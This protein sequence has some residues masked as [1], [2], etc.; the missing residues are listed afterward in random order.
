M[1]IKHLE[2]IICIHCGGEL[3]TD[4]QNERIKNGIIKC[5][6]CDAAFPVINYIPRLLKDELLLNC[7]TF[8]YDEHIKSNTELLAFHNKFFKNVSEK[9]INKFK[10]LKLDTQKTFGYEWKIWKK[11][12]DYAEN[13]F[14]EVVQIEPKYFKGK[15][16]WD[17]AVGMG[18]FLASAVEA[19]GEN[20]F[21]IGSDLS[22]AVDQAFERCKNSSNILIVQA[23]LY[24]DIIKNNSL[25]FAYMI[26]L[27]QHLTEPKK[28]VEQ[29]F[30]KVKNEGY[31]AGTYYNQPNKNDYL[32]RMVIATI[33][34][35]RIFTT[36]LPLPVVLFISRL[37]AL[38]SYLFFKLPTFILKKFNYI[39]EM[40][41]LY[42]TH[43]TQK[44]KP[45]FDLLAHNWFDHFTPPVINFFSE[46]EIMET[47]KDISTDK[48]TYKQGVLLCFKK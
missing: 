40:E 20:G 4:N 1:Y 35:M 36:K 19:V 30:R 3:S 17:P 9:E 48:L 13:H 6:K 29:V 26:G 7:L 16:G 2:H 5:K 22:F 31:F 45:D 32:M 47:V 10:K 21:M 42:P 46:D 41:E 44:R 8:Y 15:I 43:Q 24:T 39:Q 12:P 14:M 38:P 33:M 11:L 28:G 37:F 27:I 18:R 34:F 23:D 25:D